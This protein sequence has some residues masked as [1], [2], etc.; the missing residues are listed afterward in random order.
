MR[1]IFMGTPDFAVP[2]FKAMAEAGHEVSAVVTQPDR[3]RGRG[4]KEAPPPVKEAARSLTIPVF[5][6]TR[7]KDPDFITLLKGLSPDVIVVVAFG[8]ILTAEILSIPRYGCINVHA[9]LL[10]KYRG[11]APIH[12]AVINGEKE[13]GIT[14]MY[15]DEGMDTGDMILRETVPIDDSDTVSVVH[16]RL[17]LLGAQALVKTLYLIERG[18]APRQP[19]TGTLTYAPMLKAGDELILWER[20][21]R[22]ICNQIRGMNSWPGARTTFSGRVLKIWSAAALE[23][24]GT[25]GSPGQVLSSGGAGIIVKTGGGRLSIAELQLQGA[26]RLS[27][28]DFLRGTPV[29]PGTILGGAAIPL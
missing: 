7:I 8:R 10:P 16:D 28:A 12:W 20:P 9:S 4:K 2:S 3:P 22:D 21:A 14:T 5:Q 6:P 23:D 19:Q 17:S 29:L 27:S 13:T 1:A 25:A 24:D 26:K 15:M 18:Q 11:A